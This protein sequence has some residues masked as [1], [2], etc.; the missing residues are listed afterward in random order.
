MQTES[1]S[2]TNFYVSLCTPVL[3]YSYVEVPYLCNGY[4]SNPCLYIFD[5][6]LGQTSNPEVMTQSPDM[7]Y[8]MSKL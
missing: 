6:V 5:S 4:K 8:N 1:E 2:Y 7:L 3:I